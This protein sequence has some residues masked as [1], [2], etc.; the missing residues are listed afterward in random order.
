MDERPTPDD[1]YRK[2]GEASE[3]AQLL[4]TDLGTMLLFLEGADKAC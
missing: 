3:A 1:F 2:F 4:E